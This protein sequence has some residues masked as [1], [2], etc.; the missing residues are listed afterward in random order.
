MLVQSWP[1]GLHGIAPVIWL[2]PTGASQIDASYLSIQTLPTRTISSP[3]AN[4][5]LQSASH[6]GGPAGPCGPVGPCGPGTP[7]GPCGPCG[8]VWLQLIKV[9]SLLQFV[10]A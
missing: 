1:L 2:P 3:G 10:T 5:V 7:C 9:S 6:A 4:P 8:P